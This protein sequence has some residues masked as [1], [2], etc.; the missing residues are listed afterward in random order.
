MNSEKHPECEKCPDRKLAERVRNLKENLECV[1]ILLFICSLFVIPI[2]MVVHSVITYRTILIYEGKLLYADR[3]TLIF[4]DGKKFTSD[5]TPIFSDDLNLTVLY[6]FQ[7]R[8]DGILIK[9]CTYQILE[10]QN[11]IAF[12]LWTKPMFGLGTNHVLID[13]GV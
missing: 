8:Y 10:Q 13:M 1:L 7:W 2:A 6:D 11:S 5:K 3:S 9:G 12:F 4:E